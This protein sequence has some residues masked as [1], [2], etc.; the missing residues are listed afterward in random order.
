MSSA[1]VRR[2]K[3]KTLIPAMP[4]EMNDLRIRVLQEVDQIVDTSSSVRI[5][6]KEV[7]KA[8]LAH[9]PLDLTQILI[10]VQRLTARTP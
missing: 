2:D 5:E 8:R 1:P 3:Y 6:V 7:S 10:Q 4:A 9:A